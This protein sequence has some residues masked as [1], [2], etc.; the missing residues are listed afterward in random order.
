MGPV[1]AGGT[2]DLV[3]APGAHKLEAHIQGVEAFTEHSVTLIPNQVAEWLW[4]EDAPR[5]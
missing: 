5:P 3:L 2:L 1:P 4:G